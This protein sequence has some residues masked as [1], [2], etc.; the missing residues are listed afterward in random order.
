[1]KKYILSDIFSSGY[2]KKYL[3]D[4]TEEKKKMKK[5]FFIDIIH[6][7]CYKIFLVLDDIIFTNN[8]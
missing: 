8:S 5:R 3:L 1:M 7:K 6:H 4:R 2:W